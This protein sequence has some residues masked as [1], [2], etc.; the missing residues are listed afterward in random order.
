MGQDANGTVP[1]VNAP[2]RLRLPRAGVAET[3]EPELT[4]RRVG[5]SATIDCQVAAG[6][7]P[8]DQGSANKALEVFVRYAVTGAARLTDART[9]AAVEYGAT[10][11][12]E[13][14]AKYGR[15]HRPLGAIASEAVFD[16]L[17]DDERAMVMAVA[18]GADPDQVARL[19]RDAIAA[20]AA[21]GSVDL[22]AAAPSEEAVRGNS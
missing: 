20:A 9:G 2:R 4:V 18:D 5:R 14:E 22:A 17:S 10:G 1:V 8:D 7:R 21:P 16:A 11:W 19:V 13:L 12:R 15:P 3:M 6:L